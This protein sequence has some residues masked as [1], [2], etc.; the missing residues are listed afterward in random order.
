R[1]NGI[2]NSA[3]RRKRLGG[4]RRSFSTVVH[5]I[6]PWHRTLRRRLESRVSL[7]CGSR[8]LQPLD[9]NDPARRIRAARD[10]LGTHFPKLRGLRELKLWTSS[11]GEEAH[12]PSLLQKRKT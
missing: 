12:G 2:G 5:D 10:H 4:R 6:A 9:H 8:P 3:F 1:R 7:W 11:L